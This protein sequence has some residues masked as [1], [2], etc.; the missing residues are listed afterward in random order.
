MAHL[1]GP[2]TELAAVLGVPVV[3]LRAAIPEE[4]LPG[5]LMQALGRSRGLSAKAL[6]ASAPD[7]L[8]K[9]RRAFRLG[10]AAV[11]GWAE[12]AQAKTTAQP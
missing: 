11:S 3:R 6:T 4:L 7:L 8:R 5:S 10:T 12:A 1:D 2:L 9:I